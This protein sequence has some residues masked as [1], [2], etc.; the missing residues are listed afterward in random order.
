MMR[1]YKKYVTNQ[2]YPEGCIAERYILEESMMYCMDYMPDKMLGSHKRV[3]KIFY[4]EGDDNADN[5]Q[6]DKKGKSYLLTNVQ[7]QQA[8]RWVLQHHAENAQWLGKY[9]E[10]IH[11]QTRKGQN[12]RGNPSVQKEV[13]YNAWLREQLENEE[14]SQFKRI[15]TG[16][17]YDATSYS[18]YSVNG[19]V[20]CTSDSEKNLTTQNSGVSMKALT[21][22]R[23]S[24][25]D[26]NLVE[27][28]ATYY[29]RFRRNIKEEDEP[30]IHASQAAQVFYCKD[31]TRD[32]WHVVLDVPKRLTKD[33]YAFEDPLVFEAG[34]T[35]GSSSPSL[36]DDLYDPTSEDIQEGSY[37]EIVSSNPRIQKRKRN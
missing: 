14:M 33:A 8:R 16:P 32:D 36:I 1:T 37:V 31:P 5:F 21:M 3:K 9:N 11:G 17:S 19:Y 20:F 23:A 10:Y 6:I 30:F 4:D 34:L 27:Q 13:D 29:G 2:T 12:R 15:A 22:F 26:K 25:R 24:A 18:T 28:E 35:A 7:Y